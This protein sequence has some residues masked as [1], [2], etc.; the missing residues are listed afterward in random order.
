MA[1]VKVEVKV[2]RLYLLLSLLLLATVGWPKVVLWNSVLVL[3]TIS[4]LKTSIFK[5][6]LTS[7]SGIYS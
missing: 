2:E 1:E 6:K 4:E 5:Q 3:L 7:I